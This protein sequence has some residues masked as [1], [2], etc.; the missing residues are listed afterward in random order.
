MKIHGYI[1]PLNFFTGAELT[2]FQLIFTESQRT[3]TDLNLVCDA[4]YFTF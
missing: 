2:E 3:L 4:D 1:A